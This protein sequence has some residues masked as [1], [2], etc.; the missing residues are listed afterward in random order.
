MSYDISEAFATDRTGDV[1]PSELES[2]NVS[3]TQ[4]RTS[5][6]SHGVGISFVLDDADDTGTN[7]LYRTLVDTWRDRDLGPGDE[8]ELVENYAPDFL[9]GDDY[10]LLFSSSGWKAGMDRGHGWSQWYK[11]H[12]KLQRKSVDPVTGEVEY[13]TPPTSLSL[14]VEPQINGLTYEDGNE[15]HLPFGEGSRV[16]VQTTYCERGTKVVS[17]AL[18]ALTTAVGSD[19]VDAGELKRD[20]CRIWKAEAHV[21]FNIDHKHAVVRT[22]QKTEQLV[23]VAGG[24][25]IETW[26]QRQAEGWLEARVESDRFDRLGFDPA[27]TTRIEYGEEVET[28]YSEALKVYQSSDW[29]EK[30][31]SE[32]AHHPKLEAYIGSQRGEASP[33]L[34]EWDDV[35]RRLRE[36]VCSHLE[37][38]GVPDSALIG[39]DYFKPDLQP[40]F[41]WEHPEGRR[42]DL[43]AYYDRF[44]SVIYGECLKAQTDAVYDILSVITEHNG[45]T[46]DLLESTTGFSRSNLQYH[47]SRLKRAGLLTTVGNPC[48]ITFD[49][50]YLYELADEIV[51]EIGAVHFDESTVAA[52]RMGREDRAREREEAREQRG[53][54]SDDLEEDDELQEGSDEDRR[55][56][57][58]LDQWGGTP[59]MLID[60]L[61]DDE[62]LRDE[63]DIRV[64]ELPGDPT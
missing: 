46:Y 12:L 11:Y 6:I 39:D 33:H 31:R 35:M 3:R 61:T 2:G 57:V 29:H 28:R 4:T 10:V 15:V 48:V 37:W 55:P 50:G 19:I 18:R 45:A 53:E 23:D 52:R 63:R 41:Q 25:E 43:R 36:L 17:R 8:I 40:G 22:L 20:S 27:T 26:K 5:P 14:T 16:S 64:R 51:D 59:Q 13:D 24:A 54:D 62:S 58:Y 7:R 49:A 21:R 44:E 38:A 42:E 56:F 1:T 9:P 47:V 32:Y 34:D 30:S 60:Q